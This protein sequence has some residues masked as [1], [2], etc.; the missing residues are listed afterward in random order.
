MKFVELIG[1]AA[2]LTAAQWDLYAEAPEVDRAAQEMSDGLVQAMGKPTVEQAWAH[3]E[4]FMERF[5][6][7]GAADTEP[8]AV[9]QR[10]F[11]QVQWSESRA[12]RAPWDGVAYVVVIGCAAEDEDEGVQGVDPFEI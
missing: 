9:I 5:K 10:F 7:T 2:G 11:D 1:Q 12:D 4:L 6:N 3:M 8:R